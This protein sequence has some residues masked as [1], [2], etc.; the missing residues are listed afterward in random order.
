MLTIEWSLPA[1]GRETQAQ[2]DLR[3]VSSG[4]GLMILGSVVFRGYV[5]TRVRADVSDQQIIDDF[6]R[7]VGSLHEWNR[8]AR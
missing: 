7:F 2:F 5:E 4:V 3:M 6:A 8:A 1:M